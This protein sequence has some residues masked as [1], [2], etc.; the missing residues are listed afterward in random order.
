VTE[1]S[2]RYNP[3]EKYGLRLVVNAAGTFT[4]VGGSIASPEV[5]KA[6]ED[7]SKSFMHITWLQEW[8]GKEIAK[9]TGAEAGFPTCGAS[10][11]L[12]LAAAACIFK[13]TELENYEP[14]YPE[15]W[16]HISQKIPAHTEGL[17]NEFIIQK[18]NRNMYD[19]AVEV[20]GGHIIEV[21]TKEDG[22]TREELDA[23]YNSEKTAAYY[24]T[25]RHSGKRL[26]IAA[27]AE[28]AHKNGV[29][30]IV[31][32]AGELPP[33]KNLRRYLKRGAD[34]VVFSGGKSMAGP[35]NSGML[36]GRR[37]LIKLAHL[38]AYPFHGIGRSA[39]MSRET[40]VGLVTAL[41]LYL[42]RDEDHF[43][44]VWEKKAKDL[45]EQLNKI[46]DVKAEIHYQTTVE[47]KDPTTPLV[48]VKTGEGYGLSVRDLYIELETGTPS[49]KTSTFGGVLS[50]NPKYLLEGD[51]EIIIRRIKQVLNG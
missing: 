41:K 21:G 51:E 16:S 23:T 44:T 42:D 24:I 2:K 20:A 36:A 46:P 14:A 26:N 35:N 10:S 31:D 39:K 29:P 27:V 43:F 18:S 12:I 37:D 49:I 17:K 7:A 8:A 47:E 13:G 11:A 22:A 30:L 28:I 19:H 4:S 45:I 38:Q 5:F 25:D 33:K 48:Y 34:L 3:Y 15:T 32:A 40:I 1:L 6:M 50:L 9:A